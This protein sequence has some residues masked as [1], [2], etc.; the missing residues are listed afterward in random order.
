MAAKKSLAD[1][2]S[3]YEKIIFADQPKKDILLVSLMKEME[4]QFNIPF[5]RN[6]AWEK[7]NPKIHAMYRKI[8]ITRTL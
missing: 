2:Q 1:Y 3:E 8:A 5:P 6:A 7:E 4:K